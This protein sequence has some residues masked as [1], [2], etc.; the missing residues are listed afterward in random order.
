[1][2]AKHEYQ[3]V[4]QF[5]IV[6]QTDAP[7]KIAPTLIQALKRAGLKEVNLEL[8]V[9]RITKR[10][11]PIEEVKSDKAEKSD[12]RPALD[13]SRSKRG[14]RAWHPQTRTKKAKRVRTVGK[15]HH[16]QKVGRNFIKGKQGRTPK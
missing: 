9:E 4:G 2:V 1:M 11:K 6:Y 7:G 13:T 5:V 3:G 12:S 14:Q 8:F 10:G 16:V 15:V